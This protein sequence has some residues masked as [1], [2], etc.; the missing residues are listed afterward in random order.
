MEG[1]ALAQQKGWIDIFVW[2]LRVGF[3]TRLRLFFQAS[4][5]ERKSLLVDK[6]CGLMKWLGR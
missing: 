3:E 4:T 2:R 1:M 6:L 5:N